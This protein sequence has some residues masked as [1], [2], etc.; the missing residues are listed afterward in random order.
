[1]FRYTLPD[2]RVVLVERLDDGWHL[3][4]ADEPQAEIV[5]TPLQSALAELLGYAVAH[6]SWPGWLDDAAADIERSLW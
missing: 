4:L 5:G 3:Q 6:E 2:R 1:V